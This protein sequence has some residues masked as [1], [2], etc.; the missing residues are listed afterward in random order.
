MNTTHRIAFLLGGMLLAGC[1]PLPVVHV[2]APPLPAGDSLRFIDQRVPTDGK[3]FWLGEGYFYSCQY[4]IERK[5]DDILDPDAMTLLHA[6]LANQVF[7]DGQLHTVVVTRFEIYINRHVPMEDDFWNPGGSPSKPPPLVG[8]YGADQGE[9]W[10]AEVPPMDRPA[11]IVIYL[12][13]GVDGKVHRIRTVQPFESD[14]DA[15]VSAANWPAALTA[16]LDRVF[17]ALA[18]EIK[19]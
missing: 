12:T 19:D 5:K 14:R 17:A 9:Y 13:A 4:G 3:N 8:C 2:Q 6:Y 7:T 16:A 18:Q 15:K 10:S 1:T 11:P